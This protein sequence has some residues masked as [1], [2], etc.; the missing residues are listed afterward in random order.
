VSSYNL[1]LRIALIAALRGA[2]AS[3][4]GRSSGEIDAH[5]LVLVHPA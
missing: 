1:L 4:T 3:A 5:R 2:F